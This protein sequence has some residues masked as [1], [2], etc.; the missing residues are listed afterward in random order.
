LTC[1]TALK[2]FAKVYQC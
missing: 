1:Y 2:K